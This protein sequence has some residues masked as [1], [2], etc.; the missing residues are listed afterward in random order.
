M[1]NVILYAKG[2]KKEGELKWRQISLH[3]N[4]RQ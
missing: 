2:R 1:M 4:T 3:V